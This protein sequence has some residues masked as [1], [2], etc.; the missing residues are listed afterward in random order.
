MFALSNQDL[1]FE[2][3]YEKRLLD[4]VITP[5]DIG[6]SFNDIGALEDVKDTLKKLVMLPIQRPELY[7]K[8]KLT[9]VLFV[10]MHF[11]L[12]MLCLYVHVIILFRRN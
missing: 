11:N 4:N 5:S 9:K 1:V 3:E 7:T 12:L 6:V 2:D 8:G 10:L